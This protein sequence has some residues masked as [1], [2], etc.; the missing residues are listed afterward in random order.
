MR[1]SYGGLLVTVI[2]VAALV[3]APETP[4]AEGL[5]PP[6]P[7]AIC[8]S[9]A[10]TDEDVLVNS[11]TPA[12]N[13]TV[14][15]GT[16]LTFSGDSSAPLTFAIATSPALLSNPD[17]DH[18]AGETQPANGS[19]STDSFTSIT[20]TA[21]PGTIYWSV[22]FSD[23]TLPECAG[24]TPETY[25]TP[26]R[27]LTI[28][29]TPESQAATP[30]APSLTAAAAPAPLQ[31]ELK[32]A[33]GDFGVQHPLVVYRVHCSSRCTGHAYCR[34]YTLERRRRTPGAPA[35]D[36]SPAAISI[37]APGGEQ[38]VAHRYTGAALRVLRRL[39]R[40]DGRLELHCFLT[41]ST[42]SGTSPV[43]SATWLRP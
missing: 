11:L 37:A 31:T 26:P 23:S 18:G 5:A 12:E 9:G 8:S 10:Q 27:A 16:P 41:V 30:E 13:A 29:P 6:P 38:R 20:A 35:L 4:T 34:A 24:L 40:A 19:S 39:A 28:A 1:I 42:E 32:L 15:V 22:S 33:A 43:K 21:K 17:I 25:T 2:L 7:Y 3:D 14:P 36:L